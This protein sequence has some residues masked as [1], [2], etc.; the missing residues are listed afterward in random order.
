MPQTTVN[1]SEDTDYNKLVKYFQT[2]KYS[3]WNEWLIHEKDFHK[4]GKQGTVGMFKTKN[5]NGNNIKLI[6][7]ISGQID[8]LGR[9][10][11]CVLKG[12]NKISPYC[13]HFCKVIGTFLAE[14][15]PFKYKKEKGSNP[16]EITSKHPIETEVVLTEFVSSTKF[17]HLIK[18]RK[19]VSD[20]VIYSVI[21]QVMMALAIAQKKKQFTHYDL[22]SGNIL[23]KKCKKDVVFLYVIDE[24]N[25]YAIP[26]HGYYPVIIDYGYSYIS[27]LDNGPAW[28]SMGHTRH[29]FT[30][31][32]FDWVVDPKLFMITTYLD[33]EYSRLGKKSKMFRNIVKNIFGRLNIDWDCG[34]DKGTD[35]SANEKVLYML[36]SISESSDLFRE[37]D[38]FCIDILQSLVILPF[39][40]QDYSKIEKIFSIFIKEFIKIEKAVG[41]FPFYNL[42]ILKGIVNIARDVRIDY[43]HPQTREKAIKYFAAELFS[44]VHKVADYCNPK[45]IHYE[46]L[47]CSLLCLGKCIEGIIFEDME[48]FMKQKEKEY[49]KLPVDSVEHIYGILETNIPTKYSYNENT[50]IVVMDCI[51]EKSDSFTLSPQQCKDI[52]QHYPLSQGIKL[53][54]LYSQT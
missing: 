31:D 9:H 12:L 16:F 24:D 41:N 21:K 49:K 33:L 2:N 54:S 5:L 11:Y 53:Y 30:S 23:M 35:Y 39:E 37:F 46:K 47:L 10:E 7:K 51:K 28:P 29:G 22:Q 34:W 43:S 50:I 13:L 15:N 38:L 1:E 18:D 8:Y 14:I 40:K 42:Y 20:K 6:Y 4:S 17:H 44:I 3:P 25:Q 32:R 52:N 48:K 19:G 26:T 27:E 45:N 36:E